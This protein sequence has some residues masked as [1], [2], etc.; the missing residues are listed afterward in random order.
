V[1]LFAA[2]SNAADPFIVMEWMAGGSWYDALGEDPP[3]PAYQR[4]RA[5]RETASA[6]AY[7]HHLLIGIIHG[8]IKGLNVLRARD[9]SSKV[10][11]P[12]PT[13]LPPPRIHAAAAAVRLWRRRAHDGHVINDCLCRRRQKGDDASVDCARGVRR[14]V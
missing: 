6:L 13:A 11:N 1:Q 3:P 12:A 14:G 5:A 8:D 7:L 10:P 2:S 4:I 9:G